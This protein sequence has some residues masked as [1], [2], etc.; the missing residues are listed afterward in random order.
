MWT[1]S[2]HTLDLVVW[3]DASEK[4]FWKANTVPKVKMSMHCILDLVDLSCL[5]VWL[6]DDFLAP[7]K[8]PVP[9][10]VIEERGA[11]WRFNYV[12]G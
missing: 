2:A 6:S 10:E 11:A 7:P 3:W 8:I 9:L 12:V 1:N 5:R 4:R